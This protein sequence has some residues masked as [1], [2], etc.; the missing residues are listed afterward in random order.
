M[1]FSDTRILSR[2]NILYCVLNSPENLTPNLIKRWKYLQY[3]LTRFVL[4][5]VAGVFC[6]VVSHPADT[7]VSKLNQQKGSSFMQVG[8]SLGFLGKLHA[9]EI[10]P[11]L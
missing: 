6:A 4:L 11:L 3:V 1:K 5:F 10:Y 8:K 9:T 2:R 7:I